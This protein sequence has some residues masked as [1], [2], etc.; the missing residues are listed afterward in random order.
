MEH[1]QDMNLI[2]RHYFSQLVNR[3]GK[4]PEERYYYAISQLAEKARDWYK[5]S[6][7]N[8]IEGGPPEFVKMMVMDGC[9]IIELLCEGPQDQIAKLLWS[10]T[11]LF[12]DL[13]LLENQLPFFV[14]VKLYELIKGPEAAITDFCH[15]ALKQLIQVLPKSMIGNVNSFTIEDATEI[16]HLL[17]LIHNN[18]VTSLAKCGVPATGKAKLRLERQSIR[19]ARELEEAGIEFKNPD[20]N[21]EGNEMS[22]F[23]VNFEYGKMKIPTFVI[24][25]KTERI[26]RNLIAYELFVEGKTYVIDYATLMDNLVNTADDVK[27]LRSR[28]VIENMLGSDEAVAQMLTKLLDNVALVGDTFLY[29]KTF[30]DVKEHCKKPSNTWKANFRHDYWSTPWKRIGIIA[31]V[32][33]FLFTVTQVILAILKKK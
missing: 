25:D 6:V 13:L 3:I 10:R 2:K 29:E 33:G 22:L 8:S 19:C 11:T 15:Q 26:F 14:L 12:C 9:F 28:G 7:V 17:G 27:L 1:L 18:C 16:D 23:N 20:R 24:D 30:A 32:L 4:G 31:A 5:P 21:G